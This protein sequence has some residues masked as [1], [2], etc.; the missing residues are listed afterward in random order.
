VVADAKKAQRITFLRAANFSEL[1]IL[2]NAKRVRE[3][4]KDPGDDVAHKGLSVLHSGFTDIAGDSLCFQC[5]L[6]NGTTI[7]S[8]AFN[9][10]N[11]IFQIAWFGGT[12]ALL[13][14]LDLTAAYYREWRSDFFGRGQECRWGN[15]RPRGD[16]PGF[17]RR[18]AGCR[19]R[20]AR[21]AVRPEVGCLHRHAVLSRLNGGLDSG[22]LAKDNWST[23]GGV[24]FQAM[25]LGAKASVRITRQ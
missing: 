23:T 9:G 25:E 8:T 1:D 16:R 6:I 20:F 17:V 12:Y 7:N 24:R 18:Y 10:E 15:M 21:L 14:T 2:S 19:F 3:E 5:T 22:F 4:I 13:P 11:K